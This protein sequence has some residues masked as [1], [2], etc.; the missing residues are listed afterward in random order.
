MCNKTAIFLRQNGPNERH[1]WSFAL[2]N[3]VYV[4]ENYGKTQPQIICFGVTFTVKT[5]QY[6]HLL[7]DRKNKIKA[8]FFYF[9]RK[10]VHFQNVTLTQEQCYIF[11]KCINRMVFLKK[12]FPASPKV[13]RKE[14]MPF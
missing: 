11:T 12:V 6:A 4:T 1:R 13:R 2:T 7:H 9:N 5:E 10:I 8:A 3:T 14:Y